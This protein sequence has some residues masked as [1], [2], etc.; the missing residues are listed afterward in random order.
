MKTYPRLE[1]LK[2]YGRIM[3]RY[4]AERADPRGRKVVYVTSGAPVEVLEALGF[5]TVYPENYGALCAARR[6]S[7]P[8]CERAEE[9]GFGRDLC[10]YARTHLGACL[11]GLPVAD[12]SGHG[13]AVP[14]GMPRP[15][16]LVCCTNICLTVLKWYQSLARLYGCPLFVLDAPFPRGPEAGGHAAV[17]L[18]VQMEDF[19]RWAA[20][21]AGAPLDKERLAECIELSR[22]TVELWDAIRDLGARRPSP[23]NVPD[24]FI[25]MAPIVVLR[26]TRPAVDFYRLMKAELEERAARGVGAVPGERFRLLWDN[27]AVWHQLPRLYRSFADRDACFVADTYTGSWVER[28]DMA[29]P[30]AYL[31][32]TYAAPF[33]HQEAG[34]RAAHVAAMAARF[35]VDGMVMHANRSCKPFSLSQGFLREEFT[36]ATGLPVLTLEG[37]MADPRSWAEAAVKE[38]MDAFLEML[39]ARRS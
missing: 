25:A 26:G 17:Y 33:I 1:C 4:H 36:R 12:G 8:L 22:E 3:D 39:E 2:E 10:S 9:A 24:L 37:D 15:D 18:L 6:V 5:L 28:A 7:V 11:A 27:I 23:L 14:M 30:I 35:G 38:R 32:S 29:D 21:I 16:A 20:G 13:P 31:A 19:A 34:R